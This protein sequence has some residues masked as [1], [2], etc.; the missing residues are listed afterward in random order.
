MIV[1]GN[2]QSKEF[3]FTMP[4]SLRFAAVL[5]IVLQAP[6]HAAAPRVA[7]RRPI[8]PLPIHKAILD[9]GL[10]VISVP[11]DSPGIIPMAILTAGP[12]GAS[13]RSRSMT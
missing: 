13:R 10:T 7:E 12:C 11:Y 5:M 9:N 4:Q 1:H 8:F 6:A 2:T 3:H